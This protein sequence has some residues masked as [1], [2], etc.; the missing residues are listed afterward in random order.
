MLKPIVLEDGADLKLIGA[1]TDGNGVASLVG[2]T[3]DLVGP[4]GAVTD[5][6]TLTVTDA[7][8]GKIEIRRAWA[9]EITRRVTIHVRITDPDGHRTVGPAI[10]V[11][12]Q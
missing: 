1:L 8:Q 11:A 5:V 10:V 9:P 4:D 2:K 6:A 3:V 7:A 12:Y